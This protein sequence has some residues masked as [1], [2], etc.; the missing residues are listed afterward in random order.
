M[1]AMVEDIFAVGEAH[2]YR[3]HL[4]DK[5]I[6]FFFVLSCSVFSLFKSCCRCK[7][8]RGS[9]G[10]GVL[11]RVVLFCEGF[12]CEG[13]CRAAMGRAVQT[14]R[15]LQYCHGVLVQNRHGGRRHPEFG[16]APETTDCATF[17]PVFHGLRRRWN[18]GLNVAQPVVLLLPAAVLLVQLAAALWISRV[19]HSVVNDLVVCREH[20]I[21]ALSC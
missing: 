21:L 15:K 11:W 3:W 20:S 2:R 6:V 12:C 8:T 10:R 16:H 19:V 14:A 1:L 9:V 17:Q 5:H 7:A 4:S 13:F 18:T